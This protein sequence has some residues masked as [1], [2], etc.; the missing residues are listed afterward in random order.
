MQVE[1]YPILFSRAKTGSIEVQLPIAGF[2]K[3]DKNGEIQLAMLREKGFRIFKRLIDTSEFICLYL[4]KRWIFN[5]GCY[6]RLIHWFIANLNNDELLEHQSVTELIHYIKTALTEETNIPILHEK[7]LSK[8]VNNTSLHYSNLQQSCEVNKVSQATIESPGS[9]DKFRPQVCQ[10][11]SKFENSRGAKDPILDNAETVV[12]C[13]GPKVKVKIQPSSCIRESLNC[14][15]KEILIED[16]DSGKSTILKDTDP[17]NSLSVK[18]DNKILCKGVLLARIPELELVSEQL[19]GISNLF[20]N[21]GNLK[22]VRYYASQ[23][24]AAIHF[25]SNIGAALALEYLGKVSWPSIGLKDM[26]LTYYRED[27]FQLG[28]FSSFVPD[29]AH[30]RFKNGTPSTPNAPGTTI[31]LSILGLKKSTITTKELVAYLKTIL[32]FK[33]IK[34]EHSYSNMWFID[35]Y[36]PEQAATFLMQYHDRSFE[37]GGYFRLSFTKTRKKSSKFSK[38]VEK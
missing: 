29:L 4:P 20:S 9:I 38:K 35:L 3:L 32:D 8:D 13:L 6:E 25:D 21:Y 16:I 11:L 37:K 23:K 12:D 34:R 22:E 28:S 36:S 24:V 2:S 26:N 7:R 27:L 31:H 15:Q 5:S 19:K 18:V 1:K 33:R 17:C 14:S 10:Q 30:N